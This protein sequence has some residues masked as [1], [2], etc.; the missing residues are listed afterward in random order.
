[1]PQL[2]VAI[3]SLED[4]L[5][6][7]FVQSLLHAHD[8]VTCTVVETTR[9]CGSGGLTWTHGQ[10]GDR[11]VTLPTIGGGRL[12][13]R[14]VDL[15]WLRRINYPQM[16]PD[17]LE[18]SDQVEIVN[19]DCRAAILG[20]I[21]S[22]FR[23]VWINDPFA[24][25]RAENKILQLCAAQAAGLRTPRTI[26]SQD[27]EHVRHFVESVDGRAI[28]KPVKGSS[29]HPLFT[30]RVSPELLADDDAI[31]LSPAI[32]QELIPGTRHLRVHCFGDELHAFAIESQDLDWRGNIDVPIDYVEVEDELAEK[33]LAVLGR[34][35]L[36]MG[37]F[38]LKQLPEGECVWLEVNPQGQ[39]LFMEGLTG[40]PL[41][42]AF[43]SYLYR[44]LQTAA[45][46]AGS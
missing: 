23:G 45:P 17:G 42:E 6:A 10:G 35:G 37:V 21:A 38:D 40:I 25:Y 43:A 30:V 12:D 41:G 36:R 34:L 39:F 46:I 9:V 27:P 20:L 16:V 14:D 18:N 11:L 3:L 7:L 32:Y 28:V 15:I 29:K 2:Q 4:D 5:H 13:V 24:S 33:L 19:N 44:E 26:V 22:E 8:D 1:V 31:R